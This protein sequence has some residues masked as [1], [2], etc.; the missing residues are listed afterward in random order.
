MGRVGAHGRARTRTSTA[1]AALAALLT[2]A[3]P[4]WADP[5]EPP[6]QGR[7]DP[8]YPHKSVTRAEFGWGARS[9]WL[10]EPAD[11]KPE[12]APVVVFNHG[13]LAV[14]PGAYGAWIDH[15]V[16]SG[17]VVI[18][19]RYQTDPLTPPTDFL[20][21]ALAAVT[22]ALDVLETGAGHV[23]PDRDRFAL[24]GHSA[25][26]NLAAQMAA[27]AAQEHL[28]RPRA[29]IAL[30]PGEVQPIREPNL[31][32][33][34]PDTLLV[35]AAAEDDRVVGDVR[36]RQIFTQAS[37]VPSWNKKFV[38]YRTDLHGT[39]RLIAHHL[40]PTA[41][42]PRFDTGDG[43][44]RGFQMNLAEVNALDRAGFWRLAD[45]T[46]RGAFGGRT[47]DEAT[48]HGALF[49]H[50]GYWS[51][52]RAVTGPVVGDDLAQIPRVIPTNGLR[53]IQWVPNSA[54]FT[55][56][57]LRDRVADGDP[58]AIRR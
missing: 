35:V 45:T 32:A 5:P 29:V 30:M 14:N 3:L 18:Y 23:R 44:L 37:A 24:I 20:P 56:D 7:A 34:P 40:A 33:I 16:R 39:P 53:L 15:L 25:G 10:F 19:P 43:L 42:Y 12:R 58:A 38:L 4:A 22:D 55:A 52:G 2:T 51:D 31:A 9:Y 46:L 27:V 17:L 41:A 50:L 57:P 28:P 54:P 1:V 49:R 36:A 8:S 6:S 11:P 26:G 47:L 48:D 21:N 13:W